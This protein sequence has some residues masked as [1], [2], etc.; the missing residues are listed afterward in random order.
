[1]IGEVGKIAAA[2]PNDRIALQWVRL[3]AHVIRQ[4]AVI[5][6]RV[7]SS[8]SAVN[9]QEGEVDQCIDPVHQTVVD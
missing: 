9:E 3:S 5:A 1:L 7:R 2:M 6:S 4:S 8:G